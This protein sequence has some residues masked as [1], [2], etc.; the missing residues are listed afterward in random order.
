VLLGGSFESLERVPGPPE[1]YAVGA[2]GSRF[3]DVTPEA[4]YA[5]A[6]LGLLG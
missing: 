1:G 6:V 4:A 2:A 3:V 5:R